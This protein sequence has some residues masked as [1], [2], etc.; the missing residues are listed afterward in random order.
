MPLLF[1]FGLLGI[2]PLIAKRLVDA[3][4]K[5]RV[6]GRWKKPASFDRNLIV[7]GA[8]AAGLVSSYIAAAVKAKVTL[9]EGHKMGG[10][11]LNYGCVPSKAFIRSAKL[12]YQMRNGQQYGLEAVE[13]QY[14]FKKVMERVHKVIATVEPHDSVERYR[15]LGVDV[16]SGYAT[17]VDPWTVAIDDGKGGVERLTTRSIILA[18][19]ASPFVPSLPGIEASG[20][21]TSDT[22]WEHLLGWDDVPQRVVIFG[23]GP[24]GCELAQAFARFGA[25]VFLVQHG[26]RIMVREDEDVSALV[27]AVLEKSGVNVLVSHT[28]VR[29][30]Q[31]DAGRRLVVEHDG[32]EHG[33]D[34][35]LLLCAVGRS[36]R[37]SGYGLEE[38]GIPVERTVV[39]NEYLETLYPNIFAAG[40]VAG[41]Y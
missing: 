7:I 37:L 35:D 18:T 22:L 31:D 23:G 24:I 41:H 30:E 39:T 16:R 8:G 6:Y 17:L 34:Y 27:R 15:G 10:D 14:S 25:Q 1:S 40:D 3:V 20:Y 33:L 26:D 4:K 13:P 5:R 9:V 29:C 36:A 21:V 28:A 38:L 11:C 12:L 2:F 19:G 32:S